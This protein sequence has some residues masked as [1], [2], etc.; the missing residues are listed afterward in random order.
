MGLAE[1]HCGVTDSR[2]ISWP[3]SFCL[4]AKRAAEFRHSCVCSELMLGCSGFR[5]G[6]GVVKGSR[7]NDGRLWRHP[8]TAQA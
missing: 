8:V 6:F 7:R 3:T 5:W 4:W 2:V 1:D